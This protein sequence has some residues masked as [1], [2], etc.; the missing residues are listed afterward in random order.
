MIN[1]LEGITRT[2][3]TNRIIANII[4]HAPGVYELK[5]ADSSWIAM[6]NGDPPDRELVA[7]WISKELG[8]EVTLKP[9]Y[10][11]YGTGTISGTTGITLDS[12]TGDIIFTGFGF[13]SQTGSLQYLLGVDSSGRVI[14]IPKPFNT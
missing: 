11:E 14:E 12:G 5:D 3:N 7:T 1:H 10:A 6:F 9:V 4:G 8:F 13:G 2:E